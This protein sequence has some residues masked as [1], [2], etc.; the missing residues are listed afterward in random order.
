MG[1]KESRVE[2]LEKEVEGLRKVKLETEVRLKELERK[3][4]TLE[5]KEIEERNKRI[6]VEEELR[7]KIGEKDREIEGV[8]QKAEATERTSAELMQET[9]EW[10]KEKLILEMALKESEEK[11]KSLELNIVRLREEAEEAAKLIKSL[12]EKPVVVPRNV[13]GTQSE[14]KGLKLEW[15]VLAAAAAGSTGAVVAA[16]A[17]IYMYS[18]KQ[19][20]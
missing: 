11:T 13:N 7:D 20:R 2:N 15:P 5:M 1:E 3:I 14:G 4:G 17:A 19:R 12:K 10:V 16:A 18:G 8:K 6:R 9:S